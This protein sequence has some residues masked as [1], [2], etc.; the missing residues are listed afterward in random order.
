MT[1]YILVDSLH[2]NLGTYLP[3]YIMSRLRRQQSVKSPL[4]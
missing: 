1:P 3:N 2:R 4:R